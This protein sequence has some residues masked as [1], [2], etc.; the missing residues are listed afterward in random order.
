MFSESFAQRAHC[1]VR[2]DSQFQ[3]QSFSLDSSRTVVFSQGQCC[4]PRGICQCPETFLIA[5]VWGMLLTSPKLWVEA[6]DAVKHPA[7]HKTATATENY[8]SPNTNSVKAEKLWPSESWCQVALPGRKLLGLHD[9]RSHGVW[10]TCATWPL[11][12]H[13]WSC[14]IKPQLERSAELSNSA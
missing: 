10:G 14:G 12:W 5:A 9:S 7:M 4:S 13:L 3:W 6:K 11:R 8:L 2:T 1:L